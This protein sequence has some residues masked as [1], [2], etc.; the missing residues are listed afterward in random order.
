MSC[1]SCKAN[2]ACSKCTFSGKTGTILIENCLGTSC[3]GVEN[4]SF[5]ISPCNLNTDIYGNPCDCCYNITNNVPYLHGVCSN[6]LDSLSSSAFSVF[7]RNKTIP[8]TTASPLL[9]VAV[10]MTLFLIFLLQWGLINYFITYNLFIFSQDNHQ[11]MDFIFLNN[12]LFQITQIS[13][14]HLLILSLPNLLISLVART[15][16]TSH[17]HRCHWSFAIWEWVLRINIFGLNIKIKKKVMGTIDYTCF[18]KYRIS[19]IYYL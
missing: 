6:Y 16:Y 15:M 12:F 7:A 3:N 13:F 14:N 10:L 4:I 1:D 5:A 17:H 8:S 9:S 2:A 18:Y 11:V 19:L